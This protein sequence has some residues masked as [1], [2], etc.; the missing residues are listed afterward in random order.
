MRSRVDHRRQPMRD[1]ERGAAFHDL[2]ERALHQRLALGIEGAGRLVE[3]QDRRVAQHRA[4]DRNSLPLPG[5]ERHAALAEHG[6]VTLRQRQDEIMRE[7]RLGRRLDLRLARS[8]GAVGD[9]GGDSVGKQRRLL[10]H[11]SEARAERRQDR[12][13]SPARRPSRPC[14]RRHRRSGA[15]A[16]RSWSCPRPTARRARRARPASRGSSRDR[17]RLS[18]GRNG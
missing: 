4:G 6:G 3:Q 1:H 13:R 16:R 15:G 14:R 12:P 5:R 8:L 11:E 17:V 9:I 18:S 7:G 2:V 10:R